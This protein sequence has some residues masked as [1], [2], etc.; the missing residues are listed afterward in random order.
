LGLENIKDRKWHIESTC[1]TSGEGLEAAFSWLAD[2]LRP[3]KQKENE[4]E[5][6]TKKPE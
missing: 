1:A 3:Q 6:K 4:K 5:K 2:E